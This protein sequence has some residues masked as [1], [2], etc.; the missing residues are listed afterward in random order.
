NFVFTVESLQAVA[1]HLNP[2]GGVAINFFAI[3]DWLSQRHY[4]TLKA[5]LSANPIVLGSVE[6]QE[7]ILLAGR[8]FD[9]TRDLGVTDYQPL[10]VPFTASSVEPSTDDWPFLFLEGRGIPFNYLLP[11][12][13][14]FLL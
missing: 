4:D 11:L 2:G 6:N 12:F 1:Q 8:L 3:S 10:A 9:A 5:A 14:V 13:I 7:T